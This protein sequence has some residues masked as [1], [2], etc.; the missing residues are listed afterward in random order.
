MSS[1]NQDKTSKQV[2][3]N[4]WLVFFMIIMI[5][6]LAWAYKKDI[7]T[8]KSNLEMIKSDCVLW[9]EDSPFYNDTIIDGSSYNIP[10]DT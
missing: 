5:L 2:R 9:S 1:I 6:V 4:D 3:R 7:D 8:F 10:L